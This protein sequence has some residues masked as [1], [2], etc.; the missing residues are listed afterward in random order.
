MNQIQSG[1]GRLVH[2]G[3]FGAH[4]PKSHSSIQGQTAGSQSLVE[5]EEEQEGETIGSG[6]GV[7]QLDADLNAG[8][9]T[10]DDF[11]AAEI[12]MSERID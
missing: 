9:I 5:G 3:K 1:H 2:V 11:V 4:L 7:W 8:K 10:E 6:T 12:S